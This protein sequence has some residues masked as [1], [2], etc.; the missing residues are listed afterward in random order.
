MVTIIDL[1]GFGISHTHKQVLADLA[2]LAR[3]HIASLGTAVSSAI[4]SAL[5]A[6]Q[7]EVHV[8][9]RASGS[10]DNFPEIRIKKNSKERLVHMN[11]TTIAGQTVKLDLEIV[12]DVGPYEEKCGTAEFGRW[13]ERNFWSYLFQ[14]GRWK[15]G[16]GPE[17]TVV[18]E[19][20]FTGRKYGCR[21]CQN[22][23]IKLFVKWD[24][25]G[26][27]GEVLIHDDVLKVRAPCCEQV[28]CSN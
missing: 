7:P 12:D 20:E 18:P 27:S 9:F 19:S 17:P 3:P 28:D 16:R 4:D 2:T 21:K 22:F 24:V 8:D 6:L 5:G 14:W 10:C 15:F 11:G 1:P 26:S 13:N 25:T 23:K